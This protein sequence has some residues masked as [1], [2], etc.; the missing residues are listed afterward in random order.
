MIFYLIFRIQK[1]IDKK[2]NSD[3]N[4]TLLQEISF[5]SYCQYWKKIVDQI[6]INTT[7]KIANL[8]GLNWTKIEASILDWYPAIFSAVYLILRL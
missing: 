4:S 1:L 6:S 8:V 7:E 5:Q 2:W 3:E